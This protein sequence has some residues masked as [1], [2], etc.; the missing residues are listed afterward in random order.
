MGRATIRP[1]DP[2]PG[3]GTLRSGLPLSFSAR[4]SDVAPIINLRAA[5]GR[6]FKIV[7]EESYAGQHGPRA[8]VDDAA[9]QVIPGARGHVFP[10]DLTRLAGSTDTSGLTARRLK[11]LPGVTVW[12]DGS[13]GATVLFPVDL[14]DQ[15]ADLL[16]LRR[17]RR[18]SDQERSRL[19]ELGRRHGFQPRQDG[20]QSDSERRPC[21]PEALPAPEHMPA[22][23]SLFEP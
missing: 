22:Q 16:K 8:R 14:L 11:A 15:V 12:Q 20:Y 6:R 3:G 7:M 2:Q 1:S 4:G 21:V 18:V 17:R 10:W 13:D 5:Y 9:Y 19:A 23:R